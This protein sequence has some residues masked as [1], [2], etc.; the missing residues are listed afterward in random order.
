[1]RSPVRRR[2]LLEKYRGEGSFH[3]DI[4]V[5]LSFS[6]NLSYFADVL[7]EGEDGVGSRIM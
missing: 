6:I 2:A 4:R 1:M 3:F 7:W 5:V